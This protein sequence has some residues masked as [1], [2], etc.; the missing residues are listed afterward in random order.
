MF[1]SLQAGVAFVMFSL[2]TNLATSQD[3]HLHN[4]QLISQALIQT[5]IDSLKRSLISP[6]GSIQS[7]LCR[8]ISGLFQAL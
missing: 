1:G 2:L 8:D 7:V 3:S 6:L 5:A 4:L